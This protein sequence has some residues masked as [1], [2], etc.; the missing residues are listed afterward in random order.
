MKIVSKISFSLLF[1]SIFFTA[2]Q[3]ENIDEIIPKDPVFV[4]DTIEVNPLITQLRSLVSNALNLGC[5]SISYPIEFLQASGSTITVNSESEIDSISMLA[6]TLVDFVYPFE[7]EVNNATI[8]IENVEDLVLALQSCEAIPSDCMGQDAH[9]LLFF[10]AL[11]IFSIN[12]YMYTI[13]YPVNLIVEGNPVTINSDDEYLPAVGGS[14]FDLLQTKLVYPI[15]V[16]Q[17][18]KD[19]VLDNDADVCQFYKTLD[20]ACENKPAHIQFFF[21]EGA[22]TRINCTYFI[23]YPFT[24]TINGSTKQIQSREDYLD[25]LNS[26]PNA[27]G[28]IELVYP[29]TVLKYLG[30]QQLSFASDASVCEYLNNCQ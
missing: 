19:I 25:E 14:P 29:V 15:T 2:C 23:N 22:G 4:A 26:S 28:D 16:T 6:D 24:I 7:A 8:I 9:V 11:N 18:G 1:I 10:N 27:Y 30:G 3:K 12:K 17:F 13:N 21:N 5:V 20:E